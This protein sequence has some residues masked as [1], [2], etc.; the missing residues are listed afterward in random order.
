MHIKRHSNLVCF[1]LKYGFGDSAGP[2]QVLTRFSPSYIY[3][4]E[5]YRDTTCLLLVA[6]RRLLQVKSGSWPDGPDKADSGNGNWLL[7]LRVRSLW[8]REPELVERHQADVT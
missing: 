7:A 8:E 5:G 1:H 6:W 4:Y 3:F 2:H